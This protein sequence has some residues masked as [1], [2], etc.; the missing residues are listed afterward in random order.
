VVIPGQLTVN[1]TPEGAQVLVDG[2][3]N[4]NWLTPYDMTG[5][6]PGQHLVSISK[7]GYAPETRTIE[8]ASGSKSFLVVQLAALGAAAFV[9]SM[10]PGAQVFMDGKD[11][12]RATPAQ[13]Q[14]DHLGGHT[15]LV[16]KQGYLDETATSNLQ[17]G[18]TFQFAPVLRALG[19]TDDIKMV[20]KFKRMFGGGETA[21]M[22]IVSIKTQPKGAQIAVNRHILDKGSPVDFYLNPGSYL[23]DIT[24]SGYKS[25]HRVINVDRGGKFAIDEVLEPQ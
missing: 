9:T 7:L 20:G 16:R 8:V 21:G 25:S 15:F 11:I 1:S 14:V 10:P 13:I 12:G 3:H 2:H 5:L 6:V 24:V 22:G 18:Q 19:N 17:A 23:I 4:P